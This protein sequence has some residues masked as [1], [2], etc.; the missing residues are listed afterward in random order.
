MG[1]FRLFLRRASWQLYPRFMALICAAVQTAVCR[2]FFRTIPTMSPVSNGSTEGRWHPAEKCWSLPDSEEAMA[3]LRLE[4]S[5]AP[6]RA[7]LRPEKRPHAVTKRRW[8]S[9]SE[10]ER[11]FIVPVEEEM[12]LRGYSAPTRKVYRNH[13]LRFGRFFDVP[14]QQLA[15]GDIRRYLLHLIDKQQV[16]RAYHTQAISAI[17]FLYRHV[18]DAPRVV[19]KVPRPRADRT[20]PS[21]LSRGEVLRILGALASHKHRALLMTA[22]SAGLRVSEVVRLQLTDIDGERR[23]MRIRRGKGRKDRYVPLSDVLLE[24]L[25]LYWKSCKPEKWL[26]PGQRPDRHLTTRSVQKVFG[27]A[28][29]KA[30][31][32]KP[33]SMHTLRHSFATHLLE[34]G[35]DL[36][37]VQELLGHSRPETTMIYTHVTRKD[38]R[39]IR[40]PLDNIAAK[41]EL[42]NAE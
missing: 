38:L 5:Q 37:Y 19:E 26:F 31:I 32:R 17:T 25:R 41:G 27:R 40:S 10:A 4:F 21:V 24:T 1:S 23:L 39:R 34:D 28:K 20:L 13:L 11:A 8:E 16:S 14:P 18:Y 36:R 6:V 15:T 12:K 35:T 29:E 7:F 42:D 30:G 2:S 3:A 22:Y 33:V 9:L